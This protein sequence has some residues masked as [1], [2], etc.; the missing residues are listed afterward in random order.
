MRRG[1]LPAQIDAEREAT[2]LH[3]LIDGLVVHM[4]SAPCH[5]PPE[6]ALEVVDHHLAALRGGDGLR[7]ARA[8]R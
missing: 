8:A 1:E 2:R 5:A 7:P 4:V 3:A 6:L